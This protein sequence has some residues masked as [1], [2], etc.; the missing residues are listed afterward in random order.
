[1]ISET[2][3]SIKKNIK[4]RISNPFLGT[5]TIIYIIKN[6]KL[7]YGLFNFDPDATQQNKIDYI[8]FYFSTEINAFLEFYSIV[9]FFIL[10]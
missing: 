7:F 1:M 3:S 8:E 9:L 10:F 5:F 4:R 6:W 2:I